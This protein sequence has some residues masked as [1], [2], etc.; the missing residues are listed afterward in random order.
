MRAAVNTRYGPP[1]VVQV[2]DVDRPVAGAGEVLVA[3]HAT[4]V[5]RTDC[6][7]RAA[8]PFLVRP[9]SGLTKPR[10]T[11]LGNEFAGVVAEVGPDVTGFGVGDRVFGYH[12]GPFGCHAEYVAVAAD[13]PMATM[14]EGATFAQ[15]AVGTEGSHYALSFIRKV[16]IEAGQDVLV[17]GA[18]G[19]IGSAA[20]QLLVHLGAEV[21]AVCGPDHVDL[22]AGLGAHRVIDFTAE[23]FTDD[24]ARYD[25]VLDAVGKSSFGRCKPLLRPR[26]IYVSSELGP[27][28]QNPFLALVTPLGRGRRVVFPI[29][30]QDQAMIEYLRDLMAAGAF[31]PLID[32]TY[33]LDEIVEAYRYVESGQKIGN[34]VI[35]IRPE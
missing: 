29:P 28:A 22:V 14:P 12:E 3:V 35:S 9:F 17:N 31:T 4:S 27:R 18:T 32:R 1:E 8:S 20:V 5:N 15:A 11:I 2:V 21:T 24:D 10:R 16:G 23:D 13:A 6:G 25:V 30:R 7:F 19:G 34:V 33:P 26:G